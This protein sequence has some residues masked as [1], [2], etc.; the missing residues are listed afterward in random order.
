M[1]VGLRL[2]EALRYG[3]TSRYS[4]PYSELG[5]IL[6][7]FIARCQVGSKKKNAGN[8]LTPLKAELSWSATIDRPILALQRWALLYMLRR[9]IAE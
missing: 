4:H 7:G 2:T 6:T 5:D 8:F 3:Q 9:G 1:H